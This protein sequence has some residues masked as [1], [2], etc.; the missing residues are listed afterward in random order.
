MKKKTDAG[1]FG[2]Q[3]LKFT[4]L[5]LFGAMRQQLMV[6]TD[7]LAKAYDDNDYTRFMI[8]PIRTK[9]GMPQKNSLACSALDG[10]GGFFSKQFRIHDYLLG[11]RNCQRFIREFL[12]VPVS[13]NNPII[14]YGYGDHS[15][16]T[17]RLL[18]LN[19]NK[20]L[21]VIPDI[22]ISPDQKSLI[23]PSEEKEFPYPSIGFD[24]LT[25]LEGKVQFRL[26]MVM[27]HFIR[28]GNPEK[29]PSEWKMAPP[30]RR[31]SWISGHILKPLLRIA[32]NL[33]LSLGKQ[34]GKK[35]AARKFIDTVI[36][37]MSEKGLLKVK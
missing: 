20:S 25:G 26:G 35:I 16:D 24:Y 4:A 15:D 21:P 22:R 34:L 33:L 9:N 3:A 36:T 13:A 6:K 2:I 1:Y 8:A 37:D 32:T 27:D 18:F 23:L 5:E 14:C 11:R 10:F 29:L 30:I 31:Q 19:K 7:L 28:T 17:S 12:C